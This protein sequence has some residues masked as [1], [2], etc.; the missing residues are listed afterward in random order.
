ML[1]SFLVYTATFYNNIIVE[2]MDINFPPETN[3]LVSFVKLL[4]DGAIDEILNS[5]NKHSPSEGRYVT[6]CW[7]RIKAIMKDATA[8][9]FFEFR[10]EVYKLAGVLPAQE[11]KGFFAGIINA[12]NMLDSPE[13]NV[14]K[15]RID[16]LRIR[17]NRKMIAH[18][19]GR[20]YA[21]ELLQFFWSAGNIND[22]DIIDKLIKN[23]ISKS[24]DGN[25]DNVMKCGEIF[26]R[27]RDGRF[28]EALELISIVIP[29]S[30]MMKV[31]L[32]MLKARC[33]YMTGDY[34]SFLYERDSL[35]HFLKS[36]K[37]L[38]KNKILQLKDFFEKVSHMFRQ[39]E[40]FNGSDFKKLSKEIKGNLNYPV[41]MSEEMERFE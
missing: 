6:L 35:N 38:S 8:K 11:L 24:P 39:K 17:M 14:S 20:I 26:F 28:D 4:K 22:F 29:E 34:E 2:S 7:M 5:I 40:N 32:R 31:H 3:A 19:D 23:Y 10:N 37:S 27:I 9:D 15:E 30:F 21:L 18:D 33:Y 12:A 1:G 25:R 13:I 36:S 41:W 16:S